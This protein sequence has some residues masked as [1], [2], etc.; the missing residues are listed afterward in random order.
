MNY[1]ALHFLYQKIEPMTLTK[2]KNVFLLSMLLASGT[3][4]SAGIKHPATGEAPHSTRKDGL[5]FIENKGQWD[6][7]AKFM[8]EIPGGNMFVSDKGFMYDYTSQEDMDKMHEEAEAGKDA[9][10]NIIHHHAFMV[11]FVGANSNIKYTSS[12]KSETYHNYF[13]GNDPS[14]WA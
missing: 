6:N 7:R 10:K 14:K 13:I 5:Q 12:Q 9:S 2:F 1:I 11:S 3:I 4:V 8:A